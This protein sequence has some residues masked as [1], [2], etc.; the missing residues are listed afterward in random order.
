MALED[1]FARM[2]QRPSDTPET[3]RNPTGVTSKATPTLVCTPVTPDTPQ[4]NNI[5]ECVENGY[6]DAREAVEE[7][8]AILEFETELPS[9]RQAEV[10]EAARAFYQH[11]FGPGRTV[12]CCNAPMGRYCSEG[13][14]LRDKYYGRCQ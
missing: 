4:K 5:Q 14:Q 6:A 2:E 1:L 3:P 12:G 8:A 7:R 10:V 13:K 9:W 11:V